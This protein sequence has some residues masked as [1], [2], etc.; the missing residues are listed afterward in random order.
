MKKLFSVSLLAAVVF[1]GCGKSGNDLGLSEKNVVIWWQ[2]SDIQRLNPYTATDANASYVNQ[3][4]WEPLNFQNPR[5]LKLEPLLASLPEISEDHLTYTYTMNPKVHWSDGKPLTGDDVIFSF[6]AVLNPLMINSQQ[7]RNYIITVD[8]VYHPGGDNGK[9]AF[10][11]SKPYYNA[12]NVLGGGYVLILPKHILDPKNLTDSQSWADLH[13]SKTTNPAV[14]EF[15]VW[16]E[17]P[18]IGRDPKYQIGS[19]PYV[20]KE[21]VT[22][23]HITLM[24]NP[25]Y[26][27]KG[28]PWQEVY[29]DEIIYKT[30]NDQNAALT[31]L[32]AKD[33]DFM[34]VLKPDQYVN[35]D[36][37]KSN[38]LRKT[39]LFLNAYT[40]IGWNNENPLFS[41]KRVRK[42]LTMLINRDEI[43]HSVLKDLTKK[44]DGPI[45]FTQPN[46]D[47]S[48]HQAGYD[49]AAAKQLL[50]DA[51]WTD[52]D[53]DGILDKTIDGKRVPFKFSFQVNSGNEVRKQILV[54][55]SEE[56]R[57]IGIDAG[58]TPLE[59]S[60][61]LDNTATHSY[62]A[63]YSSWQG[64]AGEDEIYQLWHSSQAKNKGSNWVSFKNA[65]LDDLLTNF[66][67][68]FDKSK[69]SAMSKR[70]Q[71]IFA[72]ETPVTFMFAGPN[73]MAYTKRFEN[74][75]FFP[76]PPCYDV[77]YWIVSGSG[78]K[79]P[80]EMSM[81]SF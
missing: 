7:L 26:W 13:D 79:K 76:Q 2:L 34:D 15:A 12:D 35:L 8:S 77:R 1:T 18:E 9:V 52:T 44:D 74:V 19:G 38:F 72:D 6:K 4:I 59:W 66:R 48:I 36:T 53:G 51:G 23:S 20:Y 61:F 30:I 43:L 24:K 16:F 45:M 81:S 37:T 49:P 27:A 60:V 50:A 21:W 28:M 41:D 42:A 58:V 10:H 56:L 11:L 69:R 33:L 63:A 29:P 25:N 14:K 39:I 57:K 5:T 31:A 40:F 78:I 71:Q 73:Y 46:F 22:F 64:N 75:E 68:E 32:K 47:S 80:A 62:D 70:I 3:K 17:S 65:E 67:T 54:I 55:I